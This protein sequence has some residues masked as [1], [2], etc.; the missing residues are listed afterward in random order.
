MSR[1]AKGAGELERM[2]EIDRETV[3]RYSERY[4][5]HGVSHTTLGWGS[6]EQ[7]AYR[8]D[9]LLDCADFAGR[10][11][12]DVGCGFGDL[13]AHLQQRKIEI[14]GYVGIDVNPDLIG[15]AKRR[16]PDATFECRGLLELTGDEFASDLVVMLGLLNFKQTRMDNPLYARTMLAKAYGLCREACIA[17][18]LSDRLA[19]DYPQEDL[20]YY[21]DPCRVLADALELSAH[22]SLKHDYHPIPQCEM[23]LTVRRAPCP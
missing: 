18:F 8:F 9:R 23:M 5:V 17:D 13:L 6:R 2:R 10:T 22:A 20:V 1:A 19:P 14:A 21:Y 15:E 11:V 12:L 4:A 16:F 7:Q 3:A